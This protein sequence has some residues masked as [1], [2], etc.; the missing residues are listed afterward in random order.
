MICYINLL[1]QLNIK[2]AVSDLTVNNYFHL[3]LFQPKLKTK[4]F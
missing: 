2:I 3:H 4:D 1:A